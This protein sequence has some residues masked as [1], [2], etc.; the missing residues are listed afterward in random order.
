MEE[1]LV[2]FNVTED[3]WSKYTVNLMYF[4]SD[5]L[6]VEEF[7]VREDSGYEINNYDTYAFVSPIFVAVLDFQFIKSFFDIL[8]THDLNVFLFLIFFWL[9]FYSLLDLVAN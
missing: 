3:F 6:C 1:L 8:F 7:N 2:G 5:L 9:T 4:V